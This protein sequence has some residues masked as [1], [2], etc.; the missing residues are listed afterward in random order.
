MQDLK[1]PE[2]NTV[3]K[4][5]TQNIEQRSSRERR[6]KTSYGFTCITIVGWICRREQTRRKEDTE[7]FTTGK[8]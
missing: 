6:R 7:C 5:S 3:E 1:Q 2:K 8:L 4:F